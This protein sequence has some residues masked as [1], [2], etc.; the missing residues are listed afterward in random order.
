[1]PR[2]VPRGPHPD[3][4]LL[5]TAVNRLCFGKKL[6][7]NHSAVVRKSQLVRNTGNCNIL[8]ECDGLAGMRSWVRMVIFFVLFAL[9]KIKFDH[10]A[11]CR[12]TTPLNFKRDASEL[13]SKLSQCSICPSISTSSTCTAFEMLMPLCCTSDTYLRC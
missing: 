1:M 12:S 9:E 5:S 6:L 11:I 3:G 7:C 13:Q 4:P 8:G 2:P 10:C